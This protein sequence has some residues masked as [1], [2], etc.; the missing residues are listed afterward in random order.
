MKV[1]Y[2]PHSMPGS[3]AA[4]RQRGTTLLELVVSMAILMIISGA[5]FGLF[6]SMS[7]ASTTVQS[8]QGLSMALRSATS[9]LQMD[10]A[11][12]GNGYFQG[13]NVPSWPVGVSIVNNVVAPGTSCYSSTTGYGSNCF[14][15]INVVTADPAIY[16][17]VN[18]TDAAG[19]A[20]PASCPSPAAAVGGTPGATTIYATAAPVSQAFPSGLTLTQ[21]A[22]KFSAG[23]QLLF[24]HSSTTGT[25]ISTAI[26][27]SATV[28]GAAIALSINQTYSDGSNVLSND[29]LD[30]TS[31]DRTTFTSAYNTA[32][33]SNSC[34]P[35]GTT[36][37]YTPS[38]FFGVGTNFCGPGDWIVKLS[39]IQYTVQ[40]TGNTNDPW[41]LVRIQNGTTTVVMDQIIGFKVGASIW[42]NDTANGFTTT[43]Y[44]YAAANYAMGA[45]AEPWNFSLVRSV[46]ISMIAR[47]APTTTFGTGVYHNSFDGGAYQ[48]RGTAIVVNP[49]NLSMNDDRTQALP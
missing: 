20:N 46:R 29:P 45:L 47:T 33:P 31:C 1:I 8:Q 18:P 7:A 3:R 35:P 37:P 44:N 34:P 26:L 2:N 43:S 10:L 14:D 38:Y 39:P 49:R 6:N 24:L 12:A 17:A 30:I 5:A 41:Q 22:A 11:N 16:P 4:V 36:T 23:D 28:S 13:L 19:D 21:T 25:L 48:V 32:S 9:Q 42:N 27:R 40:A 15:S